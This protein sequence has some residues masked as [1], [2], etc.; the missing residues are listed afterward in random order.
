[1]KQFS[2][3]EKLKYPFIASLLFALIMLAVMF[4]NLKSTAKE[5]SK[6]NKALSTITSVEYIVVYLKNIDDK[7]HILAPKDK[8]SL[9]K[10]Y[11]SEIKK[12][13]EE[14]KKIN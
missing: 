9:N 7:T 12:V 13:K 14:K 3:K 10:L 5:S 6:F 2:L 4:F 8:I 1:M 11:N